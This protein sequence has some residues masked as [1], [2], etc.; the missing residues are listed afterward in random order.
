MLRKLAESHR[1]KPGNTNVMR[2][3]TVPI[4]SISTR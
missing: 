3:A 4:W 2:A 1:R